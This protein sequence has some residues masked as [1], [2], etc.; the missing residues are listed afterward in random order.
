MWNWVH[1]NT[2]RINDPHISEEYNRELCKQPGGITQ[3]VV[4]S[5]K[6]Y[7]K[8]LPLVGHFERKDVNELLIK[9]A[10]EEAAKVFLDGIL[11]SVLRLR[12]FP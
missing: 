10:E 11:D 5:V 2:H 6:Q 3:M 4:D 7:N 1:K 8:T 9:E 12:S